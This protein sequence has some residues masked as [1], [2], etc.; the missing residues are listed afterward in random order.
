MYYANKFEIHLLKIIG[1]Q[2]CIHTFTQKQNVA[3]ENMGVV[4]G[5]VLQK[6]ASPKNKNKNGE[7]L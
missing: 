6:C 1:I 4:P 2:P 7:C 3:W 5:T